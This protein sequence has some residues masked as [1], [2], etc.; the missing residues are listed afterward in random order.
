[1][2][3][4]SNFKRLME[5]AGNHKY[6]TYT[7]WI[8]SALSAAVALIPFIYIWEIINNVIKNDTSKLIHYGWM[9]VIFAVVSLLLYIGG[10]M[11]SHLSAFRVATNIRIKA[12]HHI[13]TLPLGFMD[14]FGS[15]KMRKI[16]NES[17]GATETYLAHQLPDK[18]GA[19]VTPIGLLLLLFFFDWKLG[20]LSLIPVVIAFA[21]M[22]TMSGKNMQVK[23]KEYQNALDDMSNEAVEYIRGIPV[24]KT[25]GQTVFSFKKFKATIDRYSELA[26]SYTKDLRLPM[27]FYTTA[28]NAVFAFLI[29]GIIIFCRNNIT[30]TLLLNLMFYIIIT[31]IITVTLNKLMFMN[32]NEMIVND[33]MERIDS[34][35]NLQPMSEPNQSD[36]PKDYS[37]AINN[38]TYSYDG[39]KNAINNVSLTIPSKQTVAFV[40]P[41]GSGKSTL[42]NLISRFF[43]CNNGSISIG[44]VDI[45]SIKKN[46]LMNYISFVFQNSRLIKASIYD[47]VRLS[48]PNASREEVIDALNKAQC[49][50]IIEKLPNG[51]DT[52][53]GS[54]GI[55]LSGG[56]QQRIAIARV[57]L[58][59]SPIIILDEATAF[60]DPDNEN[61]VQK[62]FSQMADG[63]TVIMIAHRLTTVTNADTIYVFDNSEIVESGTHSELLSQNGM[64][65]KMWNEYQKS[66]DWKVSA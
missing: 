25:F 30:N 15:G 3:K 1:M 12:I 32:E 5:Y 20:L 47:N 62:A 64:Y 42:A 21:I 14:K 65:N 28:I 8:L 57:I 53:I 27:T 51:I 19:I 41:S 39:Q 43:D 9:A 35:L 26:I 4:D 50:D 24:V 56:E 16:I 54:K 48:K 22:T 58:K 40:G 49:G 38:L 34:V 59:N 10:L 60:T 18:A 6:L 61:K 44:G 63:K 23:M 46:D 37:I 13:T 7:S 55:Y 36:V 2:E 17:S 52:I 66:I 45:K 33:A 31:P 29:A 11:C